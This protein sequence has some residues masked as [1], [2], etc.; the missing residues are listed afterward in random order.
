MAAG[1]VPAKVVAPVVPV[2]SASDLDA[3]RAEF[4]SLRDR[5]DRLEAANTYRHRI[6]RL[7]VTAIAMIRLLRL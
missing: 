5:I 1:K 7:V 4:A 3:L 2:A 6:N